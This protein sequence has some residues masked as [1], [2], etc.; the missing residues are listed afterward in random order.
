MR[1]PN[2]FNDTS[3]GYR[4]NE[5]LPKKTQCRIGELSW[6]ICDCSRDSAV[7]TS[8]PATP[9]IVCPGTQPAINSSRRRPPAIQFIPT[10]CQVQDTLTKKPNNNV[11]DLQIPHSRANRSF[12]EIR[13]SPHLKSLLSRKSG[14]LD[15][16]R[17][18]SSW[19]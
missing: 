10:L 19:L 14:L 11:E 1:E 2:W 7:G 18:D 6:V 9:D 15:R 13:L 8:D 17:L 3:K 4:R 16:K 5:A 12:H